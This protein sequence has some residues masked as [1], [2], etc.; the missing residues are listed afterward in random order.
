MI[1]N[2][3]KPQ[4]TIPRVISRFCLQIKTRLYELWYGHPFLLKEEVDIICETRFDPKFKHFNDSEIK[5]LV[6][7]RVDNMYEKYK[8]Q[9]KCKHEKWDCDSQIRVIE[10]KECGKRAW[11][12]DY[13]S[14][15]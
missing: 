10:C 11:I 8:Q 14:L 1:K 13:H 15:F 9:Q 12:E 6:K 4:L 2:A 3:E 5:Q 7:L